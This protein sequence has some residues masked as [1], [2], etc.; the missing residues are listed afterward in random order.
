MCRTRKPT[1]VW[2]RCR[3]SNRWG[4]R[5]LGGGGWRS[6]CSW[7][8]APWF[9][10]G[11]LKWLGRRNG[12]TS[13]PPQH[14]RAGAACAT[15]RTGI[16]C[17]TRR[18]IQ[19]MSLT[20]EDVTSMVLFARVVEERSFTRA[21][22]RLGM[23]KSAVSAQLARFE[24]RLG[25]QLLH[26]STRRM[27]LTESGLALYPR[28]ARL[29]AEADEAAALARGLGQETAG[30]LKVN[31]PVSFGTRHL[32]P[33]VGAFLEKHPQ[34]QV[35]LTV[36]DR[37]VDPASGEFDVVVRIAA[38]DRLGNSPSVTAK[39]LGRVRLVVCASPGYLR[40]QGRPEDAR[41]S[42]RPSLPALLAHHAARGVALRARRGAGLHPGAQHLLQQQRRRAPRRRRG[43]PG[44]HHPSPLPGGGLPGV[45]GRSRSSPRCAA[46]ARSS[47]SGPSTSPGAA[48][49]PR[50][51]PGWTSS[52]DSSRRAPERPAPGSA[53]A[54]AHQRHAAQLP[55][56][57]LS[58]R[59]TPKRPDRGAT[60]G[61]SVRQPLCLPLLRGTVHDHLPHQ[62]RRHPL[63]PRPAVPHLGEGPGAGERHQEPEPDLR[64]RDAE[65]SRRG[66][67]DGYSAR[68][69]PGEGEPRR[70]AARWPKGGGQVQGPNPN[71]PAGKGGSAFE[72]A[73]QYLGRNAGDIKYGKDA[74]GKA[75]QDWVPNNVNCANFVSA[76]LIASGQLPANQGSAGVI[77][78]MG[79]LDRNGYSR[80]SLK[81]A[82]PGDVV[83]MK[84]NGGQ[85][86]VLFA[87]WE[88]GKAKFIGSNNVNPDR[89]QRVTYTTM[90]YPI[91][92]VHAT[93]AEP[94]GAIQR[95]VCTQAAISHCGGRRFFVGAGLRRSLEVT[96]SRR[97]RVRVRVR[98]RFPRTGS[99]S[100]LL[101]PPSP[102]RH[103]DRFRTRTR[104]PTRS[105]T[106]QPNAQPTEPAP[107]RS[108]AIRRSASASLVRQLHE[109][110]GIHDALLRLRIRRGC[111]LPEPEVQRPLAPA[112]G[113]TSGR[114]VDADAL[115][116]ESLRRV[117]LLLGSSVE[118]A[119]HVGRARWA[120][121]PGR[122]SRSGPAGA[123]S[124]RTRATPPSPDRA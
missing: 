107:I 4:R 116:I 124:G 6:G 53:H 48:L 118:R 13:L 120:G 8:F 109:A 39:R 10:G 82:K 101:K 64:R 100:S 113:E 20:A 91:M 34:V 94:A 103:P 78:L 55:R 51:A 114:L 43:R 16:D 70:A 97:V 115:Q 95:L 117:E 49:P 26:R 38:R 12:P 32:A 77:D 105:R 3:S 58:R 86:V 76:T 93:T 7:W 74:V 31:A 62:V 63:A 5:R 90:N 112:G 22:E 19:P 27:S 52:P 15:R 56:P 59:L 75:M 71:A 14:V 60:S 23:S 17:P 28:C 111:P 25:T 122:R 46:G 92:A 11:R 45:R 44:D 21:A 30:L 41:G 89:S 69:A 121:S 57:A 73:K 72:I 84:T 40:A 37:F 36:E 50:S 1:W 81:D 96:A 68:Q 99:D 119:L 108:A 24:E 54:R 29:L 85:H 83:S 33:L 106:R 67:G 61:P 104:P 87:G 80:I 9:V 110:A 66:G 88:N 123:D 35:E 42:A 102:S 47:I 79:K 98:V 18:T 2:A 65:D